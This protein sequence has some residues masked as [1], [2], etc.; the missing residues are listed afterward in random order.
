MQYCYR[1]WTMAGFSISV[2]AATIELDRYEVLRET[3]QGYWL[4]IGYSQ[5]KFVRKNARASFAYIDK[6][7]AWE[8]YRIRVA[9]RI[10]YLE[11]DLRIAKAAAALLT[12]E[13][14]DIFPTQ[15]LTLTACKRTGEISCQE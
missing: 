6:D 2:T 15:H 14:P 12:I 11:R 13:C 9:K 3:P 7:K 4:R 1:Y 8:S 10:K 5:E